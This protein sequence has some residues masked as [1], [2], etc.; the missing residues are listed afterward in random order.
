M[1]GVR[2]LLAALH[3]D[4]LRD[5]TSAKM[6]K[7]AL[8]R[9]PKG[10]EA[11][12]LAYDGAIQRLEN[13]REGFRSLAKQLLGWLTYSKR[14]MTVK[15][16][17]NALA[18]EPG[19]PDLD[20]DNLSDIDEI[21]GFCAG[22]VI[23]DEETQVIRLVHYTTQD[24]LRT[25]GDRLLAPAQQDIAIGCLTYLLY[26]RFGDGRTPVADTEEDK[27]EE[28]EEYE[29]GEVEEYDSG[30]GEENES[31]GGQEYSVSGEGYVVSVSSRLQKYPF[32]EGI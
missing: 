19:T 1:N 27:S 6:I 23:V 22:L 25:N 9:L 17:Q 2:F 31:E 30:E 3:V 29:S 11:L 7:K 10:S 8:E 5:K 28:V 13:Q 21:M 24:Y 18:I 4:S 32:L 20:E 14:L 26:D 15:E 12:N 16:V